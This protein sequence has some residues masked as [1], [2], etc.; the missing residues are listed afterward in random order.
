MIRQIPAQRGTCFLLK[1]GHQLKVISPQ[2]QQVS[3]LFCFNASDYR[4]S[5]STG[6]TIDF[7]DSIFPS[8]GHCLF[9]NQSQPMLRICEDTCGR[10]DL[11]LTPCN[12]KMFQIVTGSNDHH[13]SCHENLVRQFGSYG[14]E[15]HEILTTFNIFMNLRLNNKGHTKIEPPTNKAGDYITF[16]ACMD[17][18]VGLTACAHEEINNRVCKPIHYEI[19]APN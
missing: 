1:K 6:R 10:H 19:Y 12:L 4:E 5:L 11:L 13:P 3:N 9:S 18:L 8:I 17:L 16:E 2:A 7:N 14:I 15:D